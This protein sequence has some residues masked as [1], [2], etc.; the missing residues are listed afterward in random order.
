MAVKISQLPAAIASAAGDLFAVVQAGITNKVTGS[1]LADWALKIGKGFLQSGTGA[2]ARTGQDKMQETVSVEDFGAVGDG[3]TGASSAILKAINAASEV[4]VPAGNF[5]I[6]ADLSV[7]IGCTLRVQRG[8]MLTIASGKKLS[9]AGSIS[10]GLYQIFAGPGLVEITPGEPIEVLPQ[11][12][13]AAP[14][15]SATVNTAAINASVNAFLIASTITQNATWRLP[16]G[17]YSINDVITFPAKLHF[18]QLKF[19]GMLT[20]TSATAGGLLFGEV[21]YS[22]ILGIQLTTPSDLWANS[23]S[24]ISFGTLAN[25]ILE[26]LWLDNFEKGL[27]LCNGGVTG[28]NEISMVWMR[29]NKS[30]VYARPNGTTIWLNANVFN[31]G[32]F[33]NSN[34]GIV[35]GSVGFDIVGSNS[36]NSFNEP[37]FESMDKGFVLTNS[38]GW[39]ITKPY[40][41]TTDVWADL[42]STASGTWIHGHQPF[43]T[44]KFATD[45]GT[46]RITFLNTGNQGNSNPTAEIDA[47]GLRF[48]SYIGADVAK[49]PAAILSYDP[50]N[51]RD[52][53]VLLDQHGSE[54]LLNKSHETNTNSPPVIGSYRAGAMCWNTTGTVGQ[55][56]GWLCNGIGTAGTLVGVTADTTLGSPTITV[57][58]ST[59]ITVGMYLAVAGGA[60]AAGQV[61][62]IVGN[63]ITMASNSGATV[64]GQVV[65]F[66]APTWRALANFA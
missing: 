57:N 17:N 50:F 24:G 9:I 13:G 66:F 11:W 42:S 26:I 21:F 55:P 22:K 45:S 47:T 32:N 14:S 28:Y 65:S 29:N 58:A 64:S 16:N 2:V 51:A 62:N 7:P 1:Q 53:F 33:E 25:S 31:G 35:S 5:S 40:F 19:E 8:G 54:Q 39:T 30:G 20:Q 52:C 38:F 41:E 59:N 12:W 23:R 34:K 6:E 4:L 60:Y 43:D 49:N 3:I 44:T 56:S 10:A 15:A 27:R 48:K 46:R 61:L 37:I 36:G 63:T 18:A